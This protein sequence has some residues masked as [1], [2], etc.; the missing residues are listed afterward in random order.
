MSPIDAERLSASATASRRKR[1]LFRRTYG[2]RTLGMG[3]AVLPVCVVLRELQADWLAWAWVLFCG[4]VWPH[5]AWWHARRSRNSFLAEQR[6]FLVDSAMVGSFLPLM[7]FNLLPS[8]ALVTITCADKINAGVRGLLARSLPGMLLATLAVGSLTGFKMDLHS[9]LAVIVASL[10]LLM[11]HT[12][13]VSAHGY[14]LMRRV[15]RQNL[16]LR[17][18]SHQD[19]LTGLESRRHWEEQAHALLQAHAAMGKPASLLLIDVD[20]FKHIND[21]HGHVVG[22]DVLRGIAEVIVETVPAGSHPGRLGGDE[23]VAAM[24]LPLADAQRIA[25]GI[26]Q[27]VG[28]L[29]WS[30][31]IG[32]APMPPVPD[33]REWMDVADRALY[34]AKAAGRNRVQASV[35]STLA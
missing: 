17:E 25:E 35:E 20:Q 10:P 14:Q 15:Q 26:R 23:F 12:L 5:L 7:H 9:T 33:L 2:F 13:A 30:V 31:S 19:G 27:G 11:I 22:D 24:P 6:N 28:A 34:K 8:A 3:V 29:G 1:E 4:L 21:R 32:I 18:L 16:R